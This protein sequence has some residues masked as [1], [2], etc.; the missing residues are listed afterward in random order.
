MER[1]Q[2][3]AWGMVGVQGL[4]FLA[5]AVTALL[6]AEPHWWSSLPVSIALVLIGAAGV[7]G[8]GRNLGASLTPSPVPNRAGLAASGLYRWVRHPM[9]SAL[10]LIC[11]GVAVG[12]GS[13]WC[14]AT[15]VVLS[16]FFDVKGRTEERYL[17]EAYD[18]YAEYAARTGK[19]I[20]GLGRRRG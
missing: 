4:L 2:V 13:A 14:Y 12:S 8:S 9:Y 16:V 5:V 18:G 11:L 19:F 7:L 6:D 17:V 1:R 20:P 15:I 10:I 3:R